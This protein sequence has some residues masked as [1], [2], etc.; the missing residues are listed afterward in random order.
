MFVRTMRPIAFP[1]VLRRFSFQPNADKPRIGLSKE[2]LN[3]K[4]NEPLRQENQNASKKDSNT[5]FKNKMERSFLGH[6]VR[7]FGFLGLHSYGLYAVLNLFILDPYPMVK[8]LVVTVVVY[9][10]SDRL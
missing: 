8:Y 6:V 9:T 7:T 10:I 5:S 1:W 3:T 2:L 4:V